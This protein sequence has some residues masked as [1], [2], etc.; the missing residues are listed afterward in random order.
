MT[1]EAKVSLMG[2]QCVPRARGWTEL[3]VVRAW[4]GHGLATGSFHHDHRHSLERKFLLQGG[5]NT[6][7]R[8]EHETS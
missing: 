6:G 8:I 1:H 3:R 5:G 7:E 2:Q 4:G